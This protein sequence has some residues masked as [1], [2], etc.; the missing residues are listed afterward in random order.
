M[1]YYVHLTTDSIRERFFLG[2]VFLLCPWIGVGFERLFSLMKKS[3]GRILVTTVCLL[4]LGFLPIYKSVEI[5]WKQDDVFV[6]AGKW[7][8]K[9]PELESAGLITNDRRIS[10]YAG[11]GGGFY[12]TVGYDDAYM[13]RLALRTQSDLLAIKRS[14]RKKKQPHQF[15]VFTEVKEFVGKKNIVE[16]YCSPELKEAVDRMETN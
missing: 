13:E 6:R 16:I 12:P 5:V 14:K 15:A 9:I 10:F 2:L 8:E 4:F 3:P 11:R 7:I 1:L